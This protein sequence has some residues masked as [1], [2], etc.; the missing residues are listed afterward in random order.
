MSIIERLAAMPEEERLIALEYMPSHLADQ[1]ESVGLYT[2]LTTHGS[3]IFQTEI[4]N[5]PPIENR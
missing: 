2:L 4:K 1:G 5:H 3:L